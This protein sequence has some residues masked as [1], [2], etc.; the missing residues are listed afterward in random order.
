MYSNLNSARAA[1]QADR[2]TWEQRGVVL[3]GVTS[4]T[5]ESWRQNPQ[6]AQDEMQRMAQD[7]MYGGYGGYGHNSMAMDAPPVLFTDPNSAIPALLTTTIDP[8]V[9][10]ILF[11]PNKAAES[12]GGEVK[13][14]DWLQDIIYFPVVEATGEVSSYGDYNEN[15]NAGINVAWPARQTTSSSH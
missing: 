4:Y 15:G 12:L 3:P 11:S 13:R 5:P 9:F 10:R 14:G 8:E 7:S 2:S 6:L 1:W